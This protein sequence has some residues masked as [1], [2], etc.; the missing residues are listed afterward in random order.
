MTLPNINSNVPR[1]GVAPAEPGISP[2]SALDMAASFAGSM[3]K[4]AA[5]G[6]KLVDEQTQRLRVGQCKPCP[7]RWENRCA[8]CGCFFA[9][10]AWLPQEDCPIGRW[11]V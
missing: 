9:K 1:N 7:Y 2:P 3:A 5:S 4:L 8:I 11:T 10:K 6:F